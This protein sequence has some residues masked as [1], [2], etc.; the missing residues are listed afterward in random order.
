[1]LVYQN[2]TK[3][4]SKIYHFKGM[5]FS[6]FCLLTSYLEKYAVQHHLAH[7]EGKMFNCFKGMHNF[8]SC[9]RFLMNVNHIA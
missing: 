5:C 4:N 6:I 8:S 3:Q 1:M 9:C 7:K 2:K